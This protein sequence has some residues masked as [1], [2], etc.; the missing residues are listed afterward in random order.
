MFWRRATTG[1][2]FAVK[3]REGR[4]YSD[5]T[6]IRGRRSRPLTIGM[7]ALSGQSHVTVEEVTVSK[8]VN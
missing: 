4:W 7:T 2:G 8:K 3:E 6:S 5:R 1:Q